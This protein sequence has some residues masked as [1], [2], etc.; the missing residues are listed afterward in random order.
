MTFL[1][2]M[3]IIMFSVLTLMGMLFGRFAGMTVFEVMGG[4]KCCMLML[5][6]LAKMVLVGHS[7]TLSLIIPMVVII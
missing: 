4:G 3:R 6:K 2:L 5:D 1:C 7:P